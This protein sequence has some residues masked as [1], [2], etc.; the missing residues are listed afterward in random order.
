MLE[1]G[2]FPK[3][4]SLIEAGQRIQHG[5]V[6]SVIRAEFANVEKARELGYSWDSIAESLG[7]PGKGKLASANFSRERRRRQKKGEGRSPA[8]VESRKSP[9]LPVE[10][11]KKENRETVFSPVPTREAGITTP[12]GRGKFQI[13]RETPEDKL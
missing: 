13:N 3:L 7:F 11:Q 6:G 8:T 10:T 2:R 1:S 9:V 4:I 5:V 12:L